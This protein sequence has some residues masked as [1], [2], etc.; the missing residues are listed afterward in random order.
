MSNLGLVLSAFRRH[1]GR[2]AF[3]VLSVAAAFAIFAILAA[4]HEGLSGQINYT[5]AQRLI[6]INKLMAGDV[7]LPV[8]YAQKIAS[9]PGVSVVSWSK[10]FETWYRRPGNAVPVL[11]F[12]ANVLKVYP[13]FGAAL[14]ERR[15]FLSDRHGAIAGPALARRMGWKV[16]DTIPLEGGPLQK[17]GST[18]WIF[19]LDGIYR[20]DLPEGYQSLFVTNY[21]YYNDGVADPRLK[22]RVH[23]F[24]TLIADPRAISRISHA[25]DARFADATPET[26]TFSEQQ[27]TLS[28]L[29]EFGDV[30]LIITCIGAAVFFSMLLITANTMANS[31]HERTGEFAMMRA[32]GFGRW[33]LSG[34]VLLEALVLMGT[35]AALGLAAGFELC[36]L[37]TPYVTDVLQ[38][39]VL[40]WSDVAAAAGLAVVF[41]LLASLVPGWRVTALPVAAAL[42]DS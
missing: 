29:R 9:V 13:E 30:G 23:E 34:L 27:A 41:S 20:A 25:I 24:D 38:A 21:D 8:S 37:M 14:A 7:T 4:L 5:L 42:R 19:H 26:M 1:R 35:G 28:G 3:T 10:Q 40:T 39:F 11:A 6:T 18:T 16:G 33:R 31:V 2:A 12:A 17:N 15:A 22:D 36:R 32:L